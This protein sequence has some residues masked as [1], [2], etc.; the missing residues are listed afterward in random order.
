M[1]ANKPISALLFAFLFTILSL[2]SSHNLH[3]ATAVLDVAASLR[4]T[5]HVLSS[6]RNHTASP[7]PPPTPP[8]SFY[9]HL[10]P[11]E[12]IHK[13]SHKDYRGLVLSR[14]GRDSARVASLNAKLQLALEN[15]TYRA[16]LKPVKTDQF[17]VEGL[18]V[19]IMSGASQGSGEYF[20]RVG[21]GS[22]AR[23]FY[24]SLD[25]GSDVNWLQCRPC[26]DCY[27]QT[28]PIFDPASS[29][30][31]RP[32][33]CNSQQ[34]RTLKV[35]GCRNG[36]Q[37]LYQVTYGDRSFT[38]GNFAT[39]TVLFGRSGAVNGIALGCGHD[40]E[41]LFVG[42]A[43]LIGLGGGPLSLTSQIKANTFSYCLVHRDSSDSST[44][45][46]NSG[47][48]GADYVTAALIRNRKMDTFY[49]VGLTGM[50]VGGNLLPISP[51]IFQMDKLGRGGII[52]DSGTAV[53]RLQTEAYNTLRDVFVQLA[54][55]QG[56]QPTGGILLFDTC[57]DFSSR[58]SV[59]VPTV[60][61]QFSGGKSWSLPPENYLI[62]MDSAGTFCFAFAPTSSSLSI[63][64]NIQQ[65]G[66]RVRFDLANSL[67]GFSPHK[68]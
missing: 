52:V 7:H 68:C 28:D 21:V 27:K 1:A 13:P 45:E 47:G 50:S 22:P 48:F 38:V 6:S 62:P 51:S 56:L 14:L 57:Y 39:E 29:S 4:R 66:T 18:S 33:S 26:V 65:Q 61:F 49:Y 46:I 16:D 10:H 15:L 53:T 8:P 3:P 55:A 17:Q 19:P 12:S 60:A 23:Q 20:S 35:S 36:N 2:T 32:L 58:S 44:L 34:C 9:L 41:G 43:G 37:C 30:T 31:Y 54:R 67:V 5:H 63:I 64:G 40:N 11:R 42:S 59:R 24:M 25:T